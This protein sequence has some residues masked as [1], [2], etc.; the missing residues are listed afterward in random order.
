MEIYNENDI[1]IYNSD[2]LDMFKNIEDNSIDL[3]IT[4]PPYGVDFANNKEYDDSKKTVFNQYEKWLKEM[5]RVLKEN[6]HIYIFIPTLEVDKW[7]S[8]V[9]EIF[10]FNNL[11]AFQ[12]HNTNRYIKNNFSFD[13]QLVIYASKGKAKRL[14]KVNWIPTSESWLKDKRNKNKNP[15]TYKYPSFIKYIK[16]NEKNNA[17]KKSFHG[18]IKNLE[19]IKIFILL[20]SQEN[21]IILDPF[22]GS[23]TTAIAAKLTNRKFIGSEKN[24]N[25]FNLIIKRINKELK[26]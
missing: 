16:A 5:Y 3:I 9:K 17:F 25:Y 14:N 23:G 8:K 24:S 20:S 4:D 10:K 2:C 15:Y 13:L 21:E 7:V 6:S 12:T 11:L 19:L 18:N 1:I 26:S 22:L